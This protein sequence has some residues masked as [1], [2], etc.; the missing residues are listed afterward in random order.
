MWLDDAITGVVAACLDAD[1][2][3]A[4]TGGLESHGRN[5]FRAATVSQGRPGDAIRSWP[6]I[7][8]R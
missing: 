1:T 8:S 3:N 2:R 6:T 7:G 4:H 5:R